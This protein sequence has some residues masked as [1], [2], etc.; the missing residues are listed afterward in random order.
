MLRI[1]C[2]SSE[3]IS[4]IIRT[5]PRR[6]IYQCL[7]GDKKL[8]EITIYKFYSSLILRAEH[9]LRFRRFFSA[10]HKKCKPLYLPNYSLIKGVDFSNPVLPSRINL[11]EIFSSV[12]R[13]LGS[14]TF[15]DISGERGFG[16]LR[17]MFDTVQEKQ[18][19]HLQQI[20][21]FGET[22]FEDVYALHRVKI[23][24]LCLCYR[25][26]KSS[27]HLILFDPFR[28]YVL[29]NIEDGQTHLDILPWF[30]RLTYLTVLYYAKRLQMDRLL[31]PTLRACPLLSHLHAVANEWLSDTPQSFCNENRSDDKIENVKSVASQYSYR[32]YNLKYISLETLAMSTDEMESIF[33][34]IPTSRL[35]K[36]EPVF[37]C[38]ESAN[39]WVKNTDDETL[40]A[41]LKHLK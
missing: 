14:L 21:I 10:E 32:P 8:Y 1:Q 27:T 24:Y 3:I 28:A 41:F 15:I 31:G 30:N 12:I 35:N 38:G 6:D 20:K 2:F 18:L 19:P 40:G 26:R 34:Y 25:F 29:K 7:F 16:I 33:D 22:Y 4:N 17:Y 37:S 13:T 9:V 5:L 39:K 36:F 23:L 11:N